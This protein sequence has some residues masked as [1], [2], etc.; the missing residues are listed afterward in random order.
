LDCSSGDAAGIRDS[1]DFIVAGLAC[2]RVSSF[3]LRSPER[4]LNPLA[5][6]VCT[7]IMRFLIHKTIGFAVDRVND[8]KSIHFPKHPGAVDRRNE[9][10]AIYDR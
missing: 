4:L 8:D 9:S 5:V 10:T 7:L 1:S 2:L 3:L 6:F